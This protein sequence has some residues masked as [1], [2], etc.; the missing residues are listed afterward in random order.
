M[1]KIIIFSLLLH[2][3]IISMLSAEEFEFVSLFSDHKAHRIG[4]IVTIIVAESSKASNSDTTQAS[5]KSGTNGSLSELFGLGVNK[6]PLKVGIDAD[7][8]YSGSGTTTRSGSMDAR[9]SVSVKEVLPNGNLLLEGTRNVT[10]ND[11]S[12]TITI[13]GV[14]RPYDIGADNTVLSIYMADAQIKYKGKGPSSS[15]QGPITKVSKALLTP[16][17]LVAGLFRKII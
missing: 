3:F 6:L 1:Q 5:K 2:I 4:D 16:F 14:V 9:I 13:S 15:S 8:G 11:D 12:Q 17:H 7:S 10:I